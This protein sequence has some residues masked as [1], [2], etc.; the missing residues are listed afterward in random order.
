M[1]KFSKTTNKERKDPRIRICDIIIG[2]QAIVIVF[3]ALGLAGEFVDATENGYKAYSFHY[4]MEDGR[5]A[6]MV[7][8]YHYNEAYDIRETSDLSEYY[9]VARYY[10]AASLYKAYLELGETEQAETY[11]AAMDAAQ[12]QMGTYAAEAD[13]IQAQLGF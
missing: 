2:I 3:L 12:A 5:Y 4:S 13:K 6:S 7:E 1:M 10:E 8:K 9:G 11:K